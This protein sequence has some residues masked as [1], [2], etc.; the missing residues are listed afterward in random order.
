MLYPNID[1]DD[2]MAA[3]SSS[4]IYQH[5][6][7]T[8]EKDHAPMTPKGHA[9]RN[10]EA[11]AKKEK[12]GQAFLTSGGDQTPTEQATSPLTEDKPVKSSRKSKTTKISG[13]ANLSDDEVDATSAGF[14]FCKYMYFDKTQSLGLHIGLHR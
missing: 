2:S 12:R 9:E 5:P 14:L 4:E 3:G 11:N 6:P 7:E 13:F 1:G 10:A 8:N